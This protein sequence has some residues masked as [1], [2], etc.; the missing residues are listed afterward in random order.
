MMGASARRALIAAGMLFALLFALVAPGAAA[1]AG[2]PTLTA[3]NA[4]ARRKLLDPNANAGFGQG[5]VKD[6]VHSYNKPVKR[7]LPDPDPETTANV[8]YYVS[9]FAP[10]QQGQ[11][12]PGQQH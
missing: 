9:E 1:L 6:F 2:A 12:A 7:P 5:T 10:G 11:N 4:G 3:T 8:G